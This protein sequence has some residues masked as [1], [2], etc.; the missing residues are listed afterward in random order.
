MS[1]MHTRIHKIYHDLNL[2]E[3]TTFPLIVFSVIHHG[4][5]TQITF[6]LGLQ[7]E[8][9]KISQN[10]ESKSKVPKFPKL[11]LPPLWMPIIS[12]VDL[13]LRWVVKQ[14]CIP[15]WD[16]SNNMWHAPYTHLNSN[17]SKLLMVGIKLTLWPPPLLAFLLAITR[18]VSI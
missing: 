5:Y 15:H 12:C 11:G 3:G 13:W 7:V 8:S 14:N 18:V 10:W 1:Q 4:G 17:N 9:P 16:F 2:G 6:F